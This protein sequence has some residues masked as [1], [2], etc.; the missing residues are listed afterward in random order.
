LA[1]DWRPERVAIFG[2]GQVGTMLGLRARSR[3]FARQIVVA[4]PDPGALARSRAAG[5]VPDHI[6]DPGSDGCDADVIVLAVPVPRILELIGRLGPHLTGD[7]LLI[8]TGSAKTVVVEAMRAIPQE[9]HAVGGH[10]MAGTE[11]PGATGA[12]AELLEGAP[13]ALTPVRDDPAAMARARTLVEALGCRP[14]IVGAEEHD[15]IVAR[16]SHLPHVAAYALT[17]VAAA[18][19][20]ADAV[21]NLSGTGLRGATRLASSDPSMVAAFLS[22]NRTEVRTALADL[23]DALDAV[24]AALLDGPVALAATLAAAAGASSETSRPS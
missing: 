22:A 15:R 23:R 2:M 17:R 18:A 20:D 8:D 21:A 13:F 12:K 3:G 10:P 11:I 5:L 24:E 4:D 1:D 14:V 19:G 7:Q 9:V 16:T 6:L